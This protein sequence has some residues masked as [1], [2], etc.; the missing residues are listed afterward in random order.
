MLEKLLIISNNRDISVLNI[1]IYL[2]YKYYN[3]F[4]HL[5]N[6][7]IEEVENRISNV[8]SEF[9]N[10]FLNDKIVSRKLKLKYNRKLNLNFNNFTQLGLKNQVYIDTISN[11]IASIKYF[12]EM[13][14]QLSA[15]LTNIYII[16]LTLENCMIWK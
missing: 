6:D 3:N 8:V 14:M 13:Q 11:E 16:R 12:I 1:L 4:K 9:K 7:E 2:Q 5:G 10:G 15:R